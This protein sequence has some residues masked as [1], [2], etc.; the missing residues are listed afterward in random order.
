M[1]QIKLTEL[2]KRKPEL[3]FRVESFLDSVR[4]SALP[5]CKI[6]STIETYG[7]ANSQSK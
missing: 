7:K 2:K 5:Y 1:G 4:N 6:Q 3:N